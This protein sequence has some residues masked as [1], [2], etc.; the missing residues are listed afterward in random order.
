MRARVRDESPH[1]KNRDLIRERYL[2]LCEKL[3]LSSEFYD[4]EF[5]QKDGRSGMSFRKNVYRIDQKRQTF[6]KTIIITDNSDWSTREIVEAHRGRWEV[7]ERFRQSNHDDLVHVR[8]IRHWT[9]SKIRCHLLSCVMALTYLRCLEL[10]LQEKGIHRTANSVM[11]D[12]HKLHSAL[13][14]DGKS[15]KPRRALEQPSKTQAEVLHA[16]GYVV[17]ASGV[18]Q[19]LKR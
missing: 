8:P 5:S 19:P 6:G 11:E 17:D 14:I 16:L 13:L 7:E 1:W 15:R 3:H 12:L 18:L 10:R 9:D 2:R 4:L